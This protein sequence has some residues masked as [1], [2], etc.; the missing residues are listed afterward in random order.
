MQIPE[1]LDF[2]RH[3]H[4]AVLATIRSDAS[5]QLSPVLVG[6]DGDDRLVVSTRESTAKARNLRR[7]PHAYV[8]AFPDRFLG[9]WVQVTG[10]AELV[11]LPEAMDGLVEYYR[12]ISGEHSDWDDYRRAMQAEHRV[13]IRITPTSANVN[14]PG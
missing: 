14:L 7:D 4:H 6:V 5:P 13:L 12:G 3:H 8:C 11:S 2:L 10:T 9:R 1:A